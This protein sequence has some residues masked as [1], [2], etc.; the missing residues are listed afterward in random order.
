M[1]NTF[2]YSKVGGQFCTFKLYLIVLNVA[3]AVFLAEVTYAHVDSVLISELDL[4]S[5]TQRYKFRIRLTPLLALNTNGGKEV[6]AF[7]GKFQWDS[8]FPV[9]STLIN[10]THHIVGNGLS[11]VYSDVGCAR[12]LI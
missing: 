12:D 3:V 7:T 2:C 5:W 8:V 9:S 4:M 10:N 1:S 6:E 11:A